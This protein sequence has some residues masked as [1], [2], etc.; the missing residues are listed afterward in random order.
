MTIEPKSFDELIAAAKEKI[1]LQH[2]NLACYYLIMARQINPKDETLES[3][4]KIAVSG[5]DIQSK[6][7]QARADT[8]TGCAVNIILIIIAAFVGSITGNFL[9]GFGVYFIG[10]LLSS[11]IV[12]SMR[13]SRQKY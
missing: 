6:Q 3:L 1:A 13:G 7:L 5:A 10:L 11:Q 9:I 2:Y 8:Q 4:M 12:A